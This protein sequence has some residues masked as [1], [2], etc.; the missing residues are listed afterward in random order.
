MIT[1]TAQLLDPK[2]SPP[3][4]VNVAFSFTGLTKMGVSAADAALGDRSFPGGQFS[5]AQSLVGPSISLMPVLC[6]PCDAGRS[7]WDT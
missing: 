4:L 6:L 3:A 2:F 1:T 7:S 5:D